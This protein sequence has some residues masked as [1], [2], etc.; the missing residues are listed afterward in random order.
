[1]RGNAKNYSLQEE[2]IIA[3]NY[4]KLPIERLCELLPDR[5]RKNIR[6]KA[7]EMGLTKPNI[8]WSTEEKKCLRKMWQQ[9]TRKQLMK[10]LSKRTYAAVRQKARKTGLSKGNTQLKNKIVETIKITREERAYIAGFL[11]G[12]GTIALYST[13]DYRTNKPLYRP[14]LHIYN[15]DKEVLTWIA[16]KIGGNLNT[17]KRQQLEWKRKYILDISSIPHIKQVLI[18]LIPYLHIK[19]KQ[20]EIV[21][22]YCSSR[23]ENWHYS[24]KDEEIYAHFC[25]LR[26]A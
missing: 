24:K 21:L 7:S 13:I 9:S 10:K 3:Q 5:K 12:E 8:V 19:R 14:C 2:Q 23:L 16:S 15:T 26:L 4:N 6:H 20:A 25:N 1:M 22:E 17:E 18:L 11:D